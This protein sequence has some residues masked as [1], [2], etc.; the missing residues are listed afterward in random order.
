MGGYLPAGQQS[1]TREIPLL[2][3]KPAAPERSPASAHPDRRRHANGP[4]DGADNGGPAPPTAEPNIG[5]RKGRRTTEPTSRA[6]ERTADDQ[7]VSQ[8]AGPNSTTG[9]RTRR[10][11]AAGPE[12][13]PVKQR[14]GSRT[15]R[16][17]T[18]AEHA[19]D[20]PEKPAARQADRKTARMRREE[21]NDIE[22]GGI[23]ATALSETSV[24]DCRRHT[25]RPMLRSGERS[26]VRRTR[27][28]A[29]HRPKSRLRTR[30]HVLRHFGTGRPAT[31][32]RTRLVSDFPCERAYP[33]T[34]PFVISVRIRTSR[35]ERQGRSVSASSSVAHHFA[36]S[37]SSARP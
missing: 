21:R 36:P 24:A 17:R 29:R 31:N 2:S 26:A 7:Q 14:T 30:S 28:T 33:R 15:F 35:R 5:G 25:E 20:R 27:R 22:G 37:A 4:T 8:T 18:Q 6:K 32:P 13:Q 1:K 16:R 12:P 11:S 19:T 34:S 23:I 9:K 10:P 3:F